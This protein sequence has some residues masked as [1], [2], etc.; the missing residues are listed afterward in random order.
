MIDLKKYNLPEDLVQDRS[1][2]RNGI[3][4]ADSNIVGRRL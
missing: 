3:Y 2:W 1:K 4:E